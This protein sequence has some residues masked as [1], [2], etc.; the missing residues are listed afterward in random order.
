MKSLARSSFWWPGIDKEIEQ[1]ANRCSFYNESRS[2]PP[3]AKLHNWNIPD[4]PWICVHMN[5]FGSI[6]NKM[7]LVVVHSYS[8]FIEVVPM[9]NNT[10][11]SATINQL[12]KIFARSGLPLYVITDNSPQWTSNEFAIF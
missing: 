9:F 1:I 3:K 4:K 6:G 11:S 7:Y 8:K 10:T 12:R 2:V 5:F